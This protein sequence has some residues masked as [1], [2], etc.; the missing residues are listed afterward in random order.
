[1]RWLTLAILFFLGAF[2][3]AAP[4]FSNPP[5]MG[6]TMTA[7]PLTLNIYISRTAHLFHVVD[8]IS[9]WSPFCHSQ[10]RRY[11]TT[12]TVEEVTTAAS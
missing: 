3:S 12:A 8:Q 10:Y 5:P 2:N 6:D 1:M 7:G 9:G 4:A 11:F